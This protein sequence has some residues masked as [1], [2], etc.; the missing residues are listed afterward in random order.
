MSKDTP[1]VRLKGFSGKWKTNKLQ[2][3]A[4]FS[5]GSGYTKQD[6]V[7]YGTPIIL[8]GR[9]YTTYEAIISKVDTFAELRNNSVVSE[10]DEVI[11]PSSGES[12]EDIARASFVEMPGII[13]GGDL[14]IIKPRSSI[15]SSF[16]SLT[17]SNGNQ[18][19]ALAKKAQGKSIVHLHNS[20]LKEVT[21]IYPLLEEQQKIGTFF[22]QLDDTIALQQQ[23]VEQQQQYKKAML[24]KMF[25]QKG[26]RVPKV[27]FDGFSREWEERVFGNIMKVTSVKRIHQSDWTTNGVRFLRA[28]DLVS[29]YKNRKTDDKLYISQEKYEEYSSISGKVNIGDLLATGVGTI[30]IPFLIKNDTPLYFKDGNIIW[31]K[32]NSLNNYF[33]YYSFINNNIQKFIRDVAGIGTVGTYTIENAKKT[34]II[35]PTFEE[36][37]K[38]GTFFKQ[39]DDTIAL[40]Q[41]KLEDYQ[42]L[43]KALLQRMFV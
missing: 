41:K 16:L 36:Q 10:G 2:N 11:V 17:I 1:V 22:K 6:L 28:R 35:F 29:A 32:N 5:K 37:Q 13:L 9:L 8:Y 21:L 42:Q 18:K 4:K 27:R 15:S 20:D 39:L 34:P 24:Q 33:F 23:L 43:K 38:I 14:N 31:F 40:H 25:P 30:G 7:K 12:S 3:L 19:K 26:D